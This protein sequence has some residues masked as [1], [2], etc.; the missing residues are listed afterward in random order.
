MGEAGMQGDGG[1]VGGG[2]DPGPQGRKQH[3][4]LKCVAFYIFF[5]RWVVVYN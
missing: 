4:A 1:F 3:Y 2:G 5:I